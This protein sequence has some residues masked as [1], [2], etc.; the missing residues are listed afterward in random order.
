MFATD[1]AL[2]RGLAERHW[3]SLKSSLQRLYEQ[4]AL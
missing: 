1:L 4:P 2:F 3:P